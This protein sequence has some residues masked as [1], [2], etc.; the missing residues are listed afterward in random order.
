MPMDWSAIGTNIAQTAGGTLLG[1]VVNQIFAKSNARQNW[2][3]QKKA[4]D[5]TYA[6]DLQMWNTMNEY[7]TPAMQMARLEQAGLNPAM[8]YGTGQGANVSKE[9][10][11]YNNPSVN[12]DAP[13]MNPLT[14][15][16]V[17]QDFK[18][19]NA[20]VDNIE[21]Q[22]ETRR[23]ENRLKANVLD[24]NFDKILAETKSAET[25]RAIL[26][27]QYMLEMEYAQ[28]KPMEEDKGFMPPTQK[29]LAELGI[30]QNAVRR[31]QAEADIKDQEAA[32]Y[33]LLMGLTKNSAQAGTLVKILTNLASF[34][35]TAIL[36]RK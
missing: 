30:S 17:F 13:I 8:M 15:L 33:R 19:K 5:Y 12:Y 21:A 18:V 1:N 34:T 14:V 29:R 24:L 28:G 35:G 27:I 25:R 7:N 11:K 3:Y 9:M 32:M 20:Q 23:L 4:A 22:T 10:P 16:S 2:K 6:K 36:K 31:T 26:D